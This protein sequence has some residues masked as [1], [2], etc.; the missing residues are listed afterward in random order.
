MN[1]LSASKYQRGTFFQKGQP[2]PDCCPEMCAFCQ[3]NPGGTMIPCGDCLSVNYCCASHR[4]AHRF[5]HKF[6]CLQLQQKRAE[7][8]EVYVGV[9]DL[10]SRGQ[11]QDIEEPIS[12][13]QPQDQP[14]NLRQ[15][16]FATSVRRFPP[17]TSNAYLAL[18]NGEASSHA[19]DAYVAELGRA[20]WKVLH[21]VADKYPPQPSHQQK[22][23]ILHFLSSF[24]AVYPC[25]KC[26]THFRSVLLRYPP[27]V[28]S[29]STLVR[30]MKFFHDQVNIT[31]GKPT[32][33]LD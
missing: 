18:S 19:E 2:A 30:W 3:T 24:A 8:A 6:V 1:K 9:R 17:R 5:K 31:L 15:G 20:A 33:G 12:L 23:D 22:Q 4:E 26:R 32:R 14:L 21:S 28:T 13:S 16:A 10:P 11:S 7:Q 25:D 27:D 29:Q